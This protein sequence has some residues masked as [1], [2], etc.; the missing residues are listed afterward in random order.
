MIIL[1]KAVVIRDEIPLRCA[2]C[3]Y[4]TEIVL[5]LSSGLVPESPLKMAKA[6]DQKQ[7]CPIPP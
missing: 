2:V 5:I 4:L 1:T 3:M 6:R 7:A